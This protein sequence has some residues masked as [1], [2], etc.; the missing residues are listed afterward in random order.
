MSA[1]AAASPKAA[2][3]AN[4]LGLRVAVAACGYDTNLPTTKRVMTA[5]ESPDDE[6]FP[7]DSVYSARAGII[8]GREAAIVS[9]VLLF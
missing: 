3:A 4:R 5:A 8:V 7:W 1:V 9:S 6:M 2:I